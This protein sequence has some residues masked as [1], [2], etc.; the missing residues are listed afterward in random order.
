M[1]SR[2][3]EESYQYLNNQPPLSAVDA[4]LE[5]QAMFLAGGQNTFKYLQRTIPPN[6][7]LERRESDNYSILVMNDGDTDEDR[8][9]CLNSKDTKELLYR[10]LEHL[11]ELFPRGY[12]RA[13]REQALPLL[14]DVY[15]S[16]VKTTDPAMDLFAQDFQLSLRGTMWA[17]LVRQDQL[18]SHVTLSDV[19]LFTDMDKRIL[20]LEQVKDL[21]SW[22]ELL[23]VNTRKNWVKIRVHLSVPATYLYNTTRKNITCY[24]TLVTTLFPQNLKVNYHGTENPFD[25]HGTAMQHLARTRDHGALTPYVLPRPREEYKLPLRDSTTLSEGQWDTLSFVEH[26]RSTSH[27]DIMGHYLPLL[28]QPDQ[29]VWLTRYMGNT[30]V[31]ANIHSRLPQTYGGVIANETGTGKTLSV[32]AACSL[33]PQEKHLILVPEHLFRHW[34]GEVEKHLEPIWYRENVLCAQSRSQIPMEFPTDAQGHPQTPSIH[35]FSHNALRGLKKDQWPVWH[36]DSVFVEEAHDVCP[37]SVTYQRLCQEFTSHATFAVTATPYKPKSLPNLFHMTGL[38]D[39]LQ[40]LDSTH[41]SYHLLPEWQYF[42][43]REMTVRHTLEQ[44]IEVSYQTQFCT[45][46]AEETSFFAEIRE[47]VRSAHRYSLSDLHHLSRFFRIME[48]IACGGR[49]HKKL[50]MQV[51]RNTFTHPRKRSRDEH[52]LVV[53][54]SKPP[55][56]SFSG[57]MDDCCVCLCS[58]S[59][60]LQAQCGHVYCRICVTSMYQMGI[61]QCGQCRQRMTQFYTPHWASAESKQG[62]SVPMEIEGTV[63]SST[64]RNIVHGAQEHEVGSDIINLCGKVDTFETQVKHRVDTQKPL[65]PWVI[66]VG[67]DALARVYAGILDKYQVTYRMAGVGSVGR[68]ASSANLEA[69]K[70]K[71]FSVILLARRMTG[72]DLPM[73]EELWVMKRDLRLF[74]NEQAEGRVT[75]YSQEFPRVTIR[76]FLYPKGFDHFLW[77]MRYLGNITPTKANLL[78]LEYFFFRE[79]HGHDMNRIYRAVHEIW[80]MKAKQLMVTAKDKY[81]TFGGILSFNVKAQTYRLRGGSQEYE[82]NRLYRRDAAY[83]QKASISLLPV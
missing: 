28:N 1:L 63:D 30:M 38:T 66:F 78:L 60:P 57:K 13:T 52:E 6:Y 4:S 8:D 27:R 35:L 25:K 3:Y 82:M 37:K 31:T 65:L 36:Y 12:R 16:P 69:F 11:P 62:A 81:I 21:E 79:E 10:V 70:K 76:V 39:V 72:I 77:N 23:E 47:L 58:F 18:V 68:K 50:M 15:F 2:L 54:K 83:L 59:D 17:N 14:R 64:F 67:E 74:L 33:R 41:S 55:T 49:V 44:Q 43:F 26:H 34:E 24:Q 48:R 32:L 80:P 9:I 56:P 46:S 7:Y 51:L 22:G 40:V 20:R 61:H 29:H 73:A 53:R 45:M 19:A 5:A 42:F 71:E 75:R